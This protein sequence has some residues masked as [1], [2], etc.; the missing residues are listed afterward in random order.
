MIK[1]REVEDPPV[2]RRVAV[3]GTTTLDDL[4]LVIQG[5][6]GWENDHL[7]AFRAGRREIAGRTPLGEALPKRGSSIQ[8]EY[9]FGDG[10]L[11]DIRSEGLFTNEPGVT[12][13]ACLEGAGACPPEDCGGAYRYAYLKEEILCDPDHSEHDEMLDWLG[14]ASADDFDPAVFSLDETNSRLGWLRPQAGSARPQTTG[15]PALTVVRSQGRSKKPKAKR[16]R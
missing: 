9:D 10:W 5:A 2:W 1:L 3:A 15:Q 4:H 16:G 14:L 13:P 6:M 7:H 8:Y 11:H 12:L